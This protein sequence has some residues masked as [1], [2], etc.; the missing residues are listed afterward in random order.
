MVG[1]YTSTAIEEGA[2]REASADGTQ[3]HEPTAPWCKQPFACLSGARAR[4]SYASPMGRSSSLRRPI[5]L[6]SA[7]SHGMSASLG[8]AS[9]SRSASKKLAQSRLYLVNKSAGFLRGE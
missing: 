7:S 8:S 2:Y 6:L 4:C 1:P 5:A 9:I 3:S